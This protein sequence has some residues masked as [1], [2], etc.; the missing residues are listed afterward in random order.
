MHRRGIPGELLNQVAAS[1]T[2]DCDLW[3]QMMI[4]DEYGLPEVV[5]SPWRAAL[6]TFSAFLLC[7]FVP[8]IPFVAELR[9]AF[10]IACIATGLMFVL[11]GLATLAIAGAAATVAYLIGAWLR[12][13]TD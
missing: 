10:P 2:A 7:G 12:G 6:L 5:R 4:R 13:L 3:V 8:L 9:N 1:I 11:I